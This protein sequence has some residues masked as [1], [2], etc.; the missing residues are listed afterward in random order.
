MAQAIARGARDIA[1]E[2]GAKVIVAFTESGRS[3]GY[4]SQARPGVPIIGLSPNV[5]TLRKLSLLW[6]VVPRYVEPLRNSDQMIDRAHA[7]L[8]AGGIVAPG[9][10]FVTIFGAPV[11]VTGSTNALQVKVVE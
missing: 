1:E 2:V 9:D 10:S 3:A 7:M 5:K 6:G 8:L 4:V 11:G